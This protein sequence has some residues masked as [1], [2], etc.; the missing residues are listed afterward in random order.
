MIGI[1]FDFP[2]KEMRIELL[3]QHKIFTG[4]AFQTNTLRL[5]PP[6]SI[7]QNEIDTFIN[8]LKTVLVS[9]NETVYLS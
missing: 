5:L 6:L 8:S 1:E 9:K 7:G 3:N 4:N 2:I